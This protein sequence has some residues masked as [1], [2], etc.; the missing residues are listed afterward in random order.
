MSE[1]ESGVTSGRLEANGRSFRAM[2]E[3]NNVIRALEEGDRRS[4]EVVTKP[5]QEPLHLVLWRRH[6]WKIYGLLFLL[7]TELCLLLLGQTL[8]MGPG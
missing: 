2:P 7:V 3:P 8:A 5:V 1:C 6:R 4:R